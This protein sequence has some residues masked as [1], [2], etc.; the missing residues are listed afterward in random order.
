MI[1]YDCTPFDCPICPQINAT[2]AKMLLQ[3]ASS[4]QLASLIIDDSMTSYQT[5]ILGVDLIAGEILISECFPCNPIKTS[6]NQHSTVWLK[7]RSKNEYLFIQVSVIQGSQEDLFVKIIR[8]FNSKH[9]RWEP[10]ILFESCKGPTIEIHPTSQPLHYGWLRNVSPSGGLLELYGIKTKRMIERG[11]RHPVTFNFSPAFAPVWGIE[12]LE[13]AFH[14]QP[15]R[16][17]KLRFR[18]T[19]LNTLEKAQIKGF[20]DGFNLKQTA[21]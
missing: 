14:R 4:K 1:P 16:H 11:E 13:S 9:Q 3:S 2:Q 18:F 19:N 7:I 17:L 12:I 10:R 5:M 20:V 6:P 15:C 8:A 21:A